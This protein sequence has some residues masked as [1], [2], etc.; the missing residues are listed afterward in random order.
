MSTCNFTIPFSGESMDILMK[1]KSAIES[2]NGSFTGDGSSG[3]F[4][5]S[6]LSNTIKGK[7]K[8]E[9][10]Q[11]NITISH[12]PFFLPCGTIESML[13]SKVS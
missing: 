11:M 12:K 9:G 7:Y 5:V 6:V 4:E 13:R 10:Q 1:A 3:H 2:Q 8:V